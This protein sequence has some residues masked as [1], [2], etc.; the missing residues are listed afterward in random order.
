MVDG[1]AVRRPGREDRLGRPVGQLADLAGRR[2]DDVDVRRRTT[3]GGGEGDPTP[4]RGLP[5]DSVVLAD[6]HGGDGGLARRMEDQL[7]RRYV[8]QVGQGTPGA[9]GQGDL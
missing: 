4:D 3:C 6:H 2:V 7:V 8:D 9:V 1:A 5:G